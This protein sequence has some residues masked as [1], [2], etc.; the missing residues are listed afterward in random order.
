MLALFSLTLEKVEM[1]SMGPFMSQLEICPVFEKVKG[2]E[3]FPEVERTGKIPYYYVPN[4]SNRYVRFP[5][6][7]TVFS[8]STIT[9][10]LSNNIVGAVLDESEF[11]IRGVEEALDVYT[12]LKERIR[13][14][15]LG[16]R[17]I[18]LNLVSSARHTTGVIA[19]YT[20]G[21]PK[22]DPHT[23]IYA[24]PIWEVKYFNAYNQ[25]HFYVL[26]GTKM[27]PSRVLDEIDCQ[28]YEA[29]TFNIP[30]NCEIIKVPET[31]RRDF[32][33]RTEEALRNLAGVQTLEGVLLFEDTTRIEQKFLLPEFN[34][35]AKMGSSASLLD[36]FP[37]DLFA[38]EGPDL[39]FARYPAASRYIHADLA[40][41][42]EAGLACVHKELSKSGKI[43]FVCDFVCWIT[44]PDR[45]YLDAIANLIIDLAEKAKVG[46]HTFS[47]D[48][49]QSSHTRQVVETARVAR[50]VEH[51]STVKTN[52]P[53][54]MLSE[55][56]DDNSFV[57]GYAPKLMGQL[58]GVQ[59]DEEDKPYSLNRTDMSDGIC[60]AV[61]TARMNTKDVPGYIY[62]GETGAVYQQIDL[63]DWEEVK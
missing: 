57:C 58:E 61:Y 36:Q 1:A 9:H 41:V 52:V 30:Q 35:S 49:Y 2:P 50:N 23:K 43:I 51:I 15:F 42:S 18:H 48:Q 31:Y 63:S 38:G 21:I 5:N 12:N 24:F 25:G 26:R 62:G 16:S 29:G 44:S 27:S 47:T 60:G 14:R 8:G 55:V 22:D 6:R 7:V 46:I 34:V 37:K 40:E 19:Q 39:R 45:I 33:N 20:K 56:V 59:L 32:T 17:F 13:S 4:Q 11:R 10:V 3:Q 53:Y 28:M 54:Q